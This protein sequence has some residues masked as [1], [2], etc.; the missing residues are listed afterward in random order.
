MSQDPTILPPPHTFPHISRQLPTTT[1]AA[2]AI[3]AMT[4]AALHSR[5]SLPSLAVHPPGTYSV[6]ASPSESPE[7]PGMREDGPVHS[8]NNTPVVPLSAGGYRRAPRS[9]GPAKRTAS[10]T[11]KAL[12]PGASTRE[13][14]PPTTPRAQRQKLDDRPSVSP[15]SPRNVSQVCHYA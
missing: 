11:L 4:S 15:K 9:P 6:P 2:E 7:S 8:S 1:I 12:G 13:S 10:G 3:T 5:M 14:G